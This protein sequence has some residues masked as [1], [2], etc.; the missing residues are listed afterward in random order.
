MQDVT[1]TPDGVPV[2]TM[3]PGM[4]RDFPIS[5]EHQM[6]NLA[7]PA[8]FNFAHHSIVVCC[9]PGCA[10]SNQYSY[11]LNDIFSRSY[12]HGTYSNRSTLATCQDQAVQEQI[13]LHLS[14]VFQEACVNPY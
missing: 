2:I 14:A 4:Q 5:Y 9:S 8:H 7:D 3:V 12:G 1:R 11:S 6:E 13:L 10:I